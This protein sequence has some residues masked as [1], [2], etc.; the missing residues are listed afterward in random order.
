MLSA[1]LRAHTREAYSSIPHL[2]THSHVS[3]QYRISV[4]SSRKHLFRHFE[5]TVSKA[6][7]PASYPTMSPISLAPYSPCTT[8]N[9]RPTLRTCKPR[10]DRPRRWSALRLCENR[11]VLRCDRPPSLE[12]HTSSREAAGLSPAY[13]DRLHM[14]QLAD[15][16]HSILALREPR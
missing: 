10:P 14:P 3:H 8:L 6:P 4:L 15:G 12:R 2:S 1:G 11:G 16:E 13:L 9:T 5:L 7:A